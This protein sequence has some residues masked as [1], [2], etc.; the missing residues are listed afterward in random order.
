MNA[1]VEELHEAEQD[2]DEPNENENENALLDAELLFKWIQND[3]VSVEADCH[4]SDD[5]HVHAECGREWN[6][7]AHN[8]WKD[9]SL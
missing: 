5:R 9:P 8:I 2:R 1:V 6:D 7:L 3:V 4:E